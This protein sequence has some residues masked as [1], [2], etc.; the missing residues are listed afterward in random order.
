[1]EVIDQ[2]WREPTGRLA[3]DWKPDLA[4]TDETLLYASYAHGY[5]AGGANPPIERVVAAVTVLVHVAAQHVAARRQQRQAVDA[6]RVGDR[7]VVR[8]ALR[9]PRL[10]A[11]LVHAAARDAVEDQPGQ[12][13]LRERRARRERELDR[14]AQRIVEE[15]LEHRPHH[16]AIDAPRLPAARDAQLRHGRRTHV[17]P[18]GGRAGRRSP[19]TRPRSGGAPHGRVGG[20]GQELVISLQS[21]NWDEVWTLVGAVLLLSAAADWWSTRLRRE[22]AVITCADWSA[23]HSSRPARSRW[24]RWSTAVVVP[25]LVVAWLASDV[26]LSGLTSPRTREL[27]GRLLDDMWPPALPPGG[28]P[29]LAEAVPDTIAMAVL[30]M[31]VAALSSRAP[32][33]RRH[34]P[35]TRLSSL[36]RACRRSSQITSIRT[37][38]AKIT[39]RSLGYGYLYHRRHLI[40][41]LGRCG[42]QQPFIFVIFPGCFLTVP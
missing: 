2:E 22:H 9:R 35:R 30:A 7:E 8:A 33:C 5:K 20:L 25:G 18:R 23:G 36:A 34:K 13:G 11:R 28:W 40:G 24:A 41:G 42:N 3:L 31:G 17:V 21:R 32:S 19:R 39:P 29:A 4:F 27:T 26:S 16:H 37:R 14:P 10:D 1:M 12:R 38:F 15:I 6:R